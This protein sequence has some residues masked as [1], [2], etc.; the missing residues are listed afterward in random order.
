MGCSKVR[1]MFPHKACED[2]LPTSRRPEHR[3]IS[4]GLVASVGGLHQLEDPIFQLLL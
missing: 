3:G 1:N 4:V 2:L